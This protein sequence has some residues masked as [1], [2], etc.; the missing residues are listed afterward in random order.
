MQTRKTRRIL[1]VLAMAAVAGFAYSAG[2]GDA[3]AKVRWKM[4]WAY[5]STLTGHGDMEK[6]IVD[7]INKLSG[8]EFA[9]KAYEPGA[10]VPAMQIFDSVSEGSIDSS[11]S[12]LG[13]W[14]GKEPAF[15]LLNSFPFGPDPVEYNAWFKWG[16]G[17]KFLDE[18]GKKHN[19]KILTCGTHSPEASGWF[20]KEIKTLD[21]LKGLKMRIFGL[22]G[23]TLEK[24]GVNSQLTA[25]GDIYAALER[26]VIDSAEFSMP[27]M[28]Y[29]FKFYEIAKH[30]Y[31]PGWH[32]PYSTVQ[33]LI[34]RAKWDALDDRWKLMW[35][36][37]C[38]RATLRFL[39]MGEAKNAEILPKFKE[40]GVT[41]H[42]WDKKFLDAF[43]AS[44]EEV[45]ADYQKTD[46][47]YK[48]V[49]DDLKEF[50]A[51]YAYWHDL[52]MP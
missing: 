19:L 22:G 38:D 10:L 7:A 41:I 2:C 26:G 11:Y 35:D 49:W 9:L 27:I 44:W 25:A 8:G 30:Y 18:V 6:E 14:P 17:G 28:D 46:P 5:P 16:N 39:T 37:V 20:R 36:A 24:L 4:A 52:A 43:K 48:A 47:F 51:K 12:P 3:D 21:D 34:N 45:S 23:K 13:F 40:K 31:F 1:S 50:R 32:Q 15:A 42:K 33:V 29:S